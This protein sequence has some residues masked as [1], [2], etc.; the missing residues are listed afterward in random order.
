MKISLSPKEF[1][2]LLLSHHPDCECFKDDVIDVGGYKLCAGCVMA[3]PIAIALFISIWPVSQY[4]VYISII[5]ILISLTRKFIGNVFFKLTL[6]GVAG[7]GLGFGLGGLIWSIENKNVL[8]TLLLI[9]GAITYGIIRAYSIK[10]KL[11]KCNCNK[12]SQ[13]AKNMLTN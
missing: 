13:N 4:S 1:N 3:Y 10:R 9:C 2:R 7:L 5:L 11:L 12:K 6:R 8:F